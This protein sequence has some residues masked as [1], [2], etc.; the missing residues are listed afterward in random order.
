M[1]EHLIFDGK[2]TID[3]IQ[4]ECDNYITSKTKGETEGTPTPIRVIRKDHVFHDTDS[5]RK[6]MEAE[7]YGYYDSMAVKTNIMEEKRLAVYE[8]TMEEVKNLQKKFNEL[9]EPHFEDF[10]S[11]LISCK[12]CGSKLST[13]H[14]TD[15]HCPLCGYDLRPNGIIERQDKIFERWNK[16]KEKLTLLEAKGKDKP[17]SQKVEKWLVKIEY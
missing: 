12:G 2:L 17:V 13:K 15:I 1:I 5:A 9:G 11:K 14:L 4:K 7:D 10:K 3:E 16:K 6:A 8:A